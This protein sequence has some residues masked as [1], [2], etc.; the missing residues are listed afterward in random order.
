MNAKG[1]K[2]GFLRCKDN[3]FH[4]SSIFYSLEYLVGRQG[5]FHDG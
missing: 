1:F 3:H 5:A 2:R 4:K